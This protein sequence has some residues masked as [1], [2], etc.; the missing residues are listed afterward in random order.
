MCKKL[1][2]EQYLAKIEYFGQ[3]NVQKLA[4]Y[5]SVLTGAPVQAG[6]PVLLVTTESWDFFA[7]APAGAPAG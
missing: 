7:P 1:V 6:A 5:A 4:Q 3:E 2:L